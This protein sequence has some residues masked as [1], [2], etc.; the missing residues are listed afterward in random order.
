[1]EL[2]CEQSLESVAIFGGG[3]W[4]RL[5]LL[6]LR[7]I[8]PLNIEIFWVTRHNAAAAH[9]LL[10]QHELTNIRI[11][12]NFFLSTEV[13]D[14][15]VVANSPLS[16][17][18]I[19]Q[20]SIVSN[21]PVLSEKPIAIT[22][23]ELQNIIN[24]S[25]ENNCP[26][27]IH[28]EL[29]YFDLRI[30]VF[31]SRL[32]SHVYSIGIEWK[33]IWDSVVNGQRKHA[34]LHA[35]VIHD[36]L[37]HCWSILAK[38]TDVNDQFAIDTVDVSAAETHLKGTLGPVGVELRLGRREGTR[39]RRICINKEWSFD[40][41]SQLSDAAS[42]EMAFR[43]VRRALTEFLKIAA[44]FKSLGTIHEHH[45]WPL[46]V[47]NLQSMLF[48][49]DRVSQMYLSNLEHHIRIQLLE[50]ADGE[51]SEQLSQLI[52]DRYLPD[53]C[54]EQNWTLPLTLDEQMAFARQLLQSYTKFNGCCS[55]E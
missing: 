45:K 36:Q 51:L 47:Q 40:F 35:N 48:E 41:D 17:F 7:R 18:R 54:K 26:C 28:L 50:K 29:H 44:N 9:E 32:D 27:G 16:H 3:R 52:V 25:N 43:P 22:T 42:G 10:A 31:T 33:D 46:S 5:L 12:Q 8:L 23:R 20:Q 1:V 11:V 55:S 19:A 34:E 13:V 37:P 30:P 15:V 49:V 38:L 24:L 53:Y 14:A 6:E 2:P 39:I 4:G 21:I